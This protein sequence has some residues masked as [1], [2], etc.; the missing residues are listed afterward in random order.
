MEEKL[1]TRVNTNRS[2]EA[3]ETGAGTVAVGCPFC[4]IMISDGVAE[5][6][7]DREKTD[8]MQVADVSQLLLAAIK[9][10]TPTPDQSAPDQI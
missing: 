9:R 2:A 10:P 7:S 6:Q 8:Q 1:G 3:I 5:L 4:R